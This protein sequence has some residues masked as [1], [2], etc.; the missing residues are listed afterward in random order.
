MRSRRYFGATMLTGLVRGTAVVAESKLH[1]IHKLVRRHTG[2]PQYATQCA[3][4]QFAMQWNDTPD[5]APEY[6]LSQDHVAA[7][8]AYLD[9]TKAFQCPNCFLS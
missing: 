9:E 1:H 4:R 3:N 8:L 5:T 2:L 6:L 7:S